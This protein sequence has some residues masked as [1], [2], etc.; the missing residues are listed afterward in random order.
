MAV[1]IFGTLKCKD[2]QKTLRF[3]KERRIQVHFV[4]L[5]EKPLSPGELT[6]IKRSIP[7][8]D[9]ID[10]NGKGTKRKATSI[11]SMISK[12]CFSQTR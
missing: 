10:K 12:R 2:T 8:K 5:S 1:Q 6:N 3:F 4:D 9:L 7:L 11:S